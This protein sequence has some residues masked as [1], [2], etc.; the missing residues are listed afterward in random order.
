MFDALEVSLT[1]MDLLAGIEAKLRMRRKTLADQ[2]GRAA[3]SISLNLS[4]GR[5]RVGLDRLD[6]LR[7]AE[8]S[9]AEL[10]AALRIARSRGYITGDDYASVDAQLD[11]VRAM[12]YRL[13]HPRN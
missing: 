9:A 12:L 6:I 4:E 13:T 10:T 2:V 8:G 3:E 7:R 5:K 11:R 1:V